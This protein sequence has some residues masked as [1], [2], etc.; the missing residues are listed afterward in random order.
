[1]TPQPCPVDSH[2]STWTPLERELLRV[3]AIQVKY[4]TEEQTIR[5]WGPQAGD[6]IAAL[7]STG[8]IVRETLE[9]YDV[10]A[11]RQP[12]YFWS[13]G[14][15]APT[16]QNLI[17]LS[18]RLINRWRSRLQPQTVY[19]A[20]REAAN[21]FG[22]RSNEPDRSSEWSH[23]L[24]LSEVFL[25]YRASHTEESACW[26]GES[27]FPKLG[28]TIKHLKDPDAFLLE[29]RQAIRVI[30][31]GGKYSVEHLQAL[32]DHCAGGAYRRVQEFASP[33]GSH[34]AHSLYAQKLLPYEIW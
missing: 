14:Q 24:F 27:Y 30:E 28:L 7:Q 13:P 21:A 10:A 16:S 34:S 8:L 9:V 5:G 12:L 11:P 1:M 25:H 29:N 3:L 22:A 26:F 4:L 6:A 19:R 32:H 17:E 18:D 2:G 23:D 15:P 20:S 33:T 31:I